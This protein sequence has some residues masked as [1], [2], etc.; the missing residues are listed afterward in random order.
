M[1]L[2]IVNNTA[3]SFV[4]LKKI[5]ISLELYCAPIDELTVFDREIVWP[6]SVS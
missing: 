6:H 1:P 3:V 2:T 5:Q 4:S